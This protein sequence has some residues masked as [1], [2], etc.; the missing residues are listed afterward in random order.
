MNDPALNPDPSLPASPVAKRNLSLKFIGVGGAGGHIADYLCAAGFP[1][2]EFIAVNTDAQALADCRASQKFQLGAELTRGLGMGGDPELGLATAEKEAAALSPL[3]A[4]ADIVFLAA[5]LGGGTGTGASPVL[6]RIARETGALVLAF[7]V[8]PFA[9]EGARR[10]QQ[11]QRG[12]QLLKAAADGVICIP[13]QKLCTLIDEKT[14]LVETF[15]LGNE[16]LAQGLRGLWR[17]LTRPG[18]IHVDFAHLAAVLRGRHSESSFAMADAAGPN[19]GREVVEKLLRSPLL[20][21]GRLLAEAETILISIAGGADLNMAEVDRIMESIEQECADAH[22]T[23]G[24]TVDQSLR[25]RVEVTLI[26]SSRKPVASPPAVTGP[27]EE[28]EVESPVTAVAPRERETNFLDTTATTRPAPRYLPPPPTLNPEQTE[29]AIKQ[30]AGA[31]SRLRKALPRL[32]QGQLPL[33][34]VSKGRFEKSEPTI[35]NGE[36]LDVPTFKRRGLVLN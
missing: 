21:E 18:L 32:R 6:A 17:L 27:L 19:R 26:A 2:I 8:M 12:L 36:D 1:D 4:G 16:L 5:G 3:C 13:N 15:R 22:L 28:I 23:L 11:A 31:N 34:I 30:H 35:H 10:Q 24:M 9:F 33:E 20:G 29:K 25:D 7:A 14:S